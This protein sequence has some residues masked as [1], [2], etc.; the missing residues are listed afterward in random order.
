MGELGEDAL[1]DLVDTKL[2][3]LSALPPAQ[4]PTEPNEEVIRDFIYSAHRD[5]IQK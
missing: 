5:F 3:E 1:R 2:A 4:L